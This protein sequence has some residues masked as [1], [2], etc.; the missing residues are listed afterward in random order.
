MKAKFLPLPIIALFVIGLSAC[1]PN[2]TPPAEPS[3][4][5]LV[6]E[7]ATPKAPEAI[8]DPSNLALAAN[9]ASLSADSSF[10]GYTTARIIDGIRNL[11]GLSW[12]LAGW[13]SKDN[14][15]DHWV[16]ISL[17]KESQVKTVQ[18]FWCLD[19]GELKSSVAYHIQYWDGKDWITA[20]EEKAGAQK[21]PETKIDVNFSTTK[22]RYFQ[23]AGGGP[24]NRPNIAW[25][26]EI[27]LR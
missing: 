7:P 23:S 10:A 1:G 14:G 12:D 26:G 9:G 16:E 4:E 20:F 15:Q 24:A 19:N 8:L 18:I 21:V 17:A 27:E 11:E 5:P 6:L 3:P 22:V 13:A 25:I 2:P